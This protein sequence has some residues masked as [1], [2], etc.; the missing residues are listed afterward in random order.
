MATTMAR[1][2][3]PAFPLAADG[4]VAAAADELGWSTS[5]PEPL[6]YPGW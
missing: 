6:P 3:V 2:P 1:I 5:T 4:R